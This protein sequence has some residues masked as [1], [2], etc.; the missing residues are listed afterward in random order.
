M[1]ALKNPTSYLEFL[2]ESLTDRTN[3]AE[4]GLS[5]L[6]DKVEYLHKISKEHKKIEYRNVLYIKKIKPFNYTNRQE[7]RIPDQRHRP[8]LQQD[9]GR[10][11]AHSKG[12][13]T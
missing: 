4:N 7:G 5:G 11:L 6:T 8:D 3:Q 2:S 10:E 9:P 1:M 13:I 12:R